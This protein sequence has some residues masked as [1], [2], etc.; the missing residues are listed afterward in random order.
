MGREP[1]RIA[2]ATNHRQPARNSLINAPDAA[3]STTPTPAPHTAQRPV[4]TGPPRLV[5]FSQFRRFYRNGNRFATTILTRDRLRSGEMLPGNPDM[6][7]TNLTRYRFSHS[8]LPQYDTSFLGKE[9]RSSAYLDL[10]HRPRQQISSNAITRIDT[11]TFNKAPSVLFVSGALNKHEHD[12]EATRSGSCGLMRRSAPSARPAASWP[13]RPAG[14]APVSSWRTAG[15]PPPRPAMLAGMRRTSGGA[16]TGPAPT[17][18]PATS[19]TT[20]LPSTS[21]APRNPARVIA[22]LAQSGPRSSVEPTVR[23]GPAGQVAMKRGREPA[24]KLGNNPETGCR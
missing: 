3:D 18:G 10:Q 14:T 11:K 16:S 17:A 20:T 22:P 1:N 21:R 12:R 19:A 23:P 5:A 15:T 24:D 7:R 13:A 6:C 4:S 8:Q 2:E 9:G